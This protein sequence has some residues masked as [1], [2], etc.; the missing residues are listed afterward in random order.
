MINIIKRILRGV[1]VSREHLALDLLDSVGP[2]GNF[3]ANTHTVKHFRDEF[4]ISKLFDR[5][6]HAAWMAE[7]GKTLKDRCNDKLRGLL[8]THSPEKLN[9]NVIQQV[10]SIVADADKR[11]K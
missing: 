6:G 7:G 10:R 4:Y 8:E 2:G 11:R 5:K 1:T 3:L 9:D